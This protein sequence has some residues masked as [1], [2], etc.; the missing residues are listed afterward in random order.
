MFLLSKATYLT[1]SPSLMRTEDLIDK[2]MEG[3]YGLARL[4]WLRTLRWI[5][6]LPERS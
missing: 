5:R 6:A 3:N 1:S 2:A 4:Y